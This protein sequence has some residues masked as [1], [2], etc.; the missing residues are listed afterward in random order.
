[1]LSADH[2]GDDLVNVASRALKT[3]RSS[4]PVNQEVLVNRR[5]RRNHMRDHFAKGRL[6]TTLVES[7]GI[8]LKTIRC[9]VGYDILSGARYLLDWRAKVGSHAERQFLLS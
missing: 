8:R 1:M 3:V 6:I 5:F 4:D 2:L 7:R 9:Q